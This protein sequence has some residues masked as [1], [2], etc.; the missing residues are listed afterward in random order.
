MARKIDVSLISGNG[1]SN[2]QLLGANTGNVSF[3]S[4]FTGNVI[5]SGN[6]SSGNVYFSNARAIG[7]LVAG[8]NIS[9]TANGLI[10]ANLSAVSVSSVTGNLNVSGNVI[11]NGFVSTSASAGIISS[12][13]NITMTAAG[14]VNINS[15]NVI[16]SGNVIANTFISTG[17]GSGLL[18]S[19]GNVSISATGIVTLTGSSI[20]VNGPLT[21]N[22]YSG[23]FT[24]NVT[25]S[26]SNLYFT[27]ARVYANVVSLLAAKANVSDLSTSNIAEGNNLYYTNA[28]V[29][30]NVIALMPSLQ[31]NNIIIAANG[32]ISANLT[33]VSVNVN[34][35]TGN[36]N[37][38]G[39]VIANG[40]V[41]TSASA[42]IISSTGNITMTAAG[43]VNI[44]ST[45]VIASGNIIA[46]TFISAGAGSGTLSSTGNVSITGVG[47]ITLNS[48]NVI[49]SGNILATKFFG[50][51]SSLTGVGA[52]SFT[53]NTNGIT[54]GSNNL[55]YTNAR[56]YSNVVSALAV[57]ST[58]N[59]A[60]GTN[61]YYTNARVLSN[62]TAYLAANP[63]ISTYGNANV[64]A[65]LTNYTGNIT[66]G[67]VIANTIISPTAIAAT[68]TST[69]NLNIT[70]L[71]AINLTSPNVIASGNIVA[72]NI[73]TGSGSGGS[74]TGA[75]LISAGNI[76]ATT[77][78]N[79]YTANVI[80]SG[81]SIFY[82]NARVLSNITAYLAANPQGGTFANANVSSLLS[83]YTGNLAAGNLILTGGIVDNVGV[84]SISTTSNSNIELTAAGTGRILLDGQAWPH[85][86]GVNGYVLQTNGTGNLFWAAPASSFANANVG[87]FLATYTGNISAGNVIANTILSPTAIA[88]TITS[89]GNLN[90]TAAGAI[91]L[92]TTNVLVSGNVVANTF[93]ATG[94]GSAELTSTSN[95]L[96]S[97]AG[98]LNLTSSNVI[99]NGNLVLRGALSGLTLTTTSIA[100]GSNLYYTNAR[101]YSNVVSALSALSTSNIAEGSNLYYTNARV[102]SNVIAYLA[103]N[104]ASVSFGNANV[105][106]YLTTY[107]GNISAGNVI[108]NSFVS[109]TATS[110][111]LTSTGN[112]N[113]TAAGTINLTTSNVLVS[114]NVVANNFISTGAGSGEVASTSNLLLSAAGNLNLTS[115]NVFVNGN[116]VLRGAL[117]G[118]TLTTSSIA[119][120]SN[121][122]YT[123]A[124]VHSNVI[125][126]LPTY[127]GNIAAGNLVLTGGIIDNVGVLSISTTG[128]SN[129]ELV[130]NGTGR[131]ILDGQAWPHTDGVNGYVLQ[132]N[133]TGNLFWGVSVGSFS[134][135]NVSSFLSTYTGN[136]TA[137]NVIANSFVS[138]TATSA[139]LTSTG[140]L[141]IT[142]AGTVNLTT[143]NVIASGNIIANTF[144]SAGAGSGEIVS[145][146]NLLLSGA[147]NVN[148]T[149]PNVIVNGNLVLRGGIT[150]LTVTTSSVAEG[151]NLYYTNARVYSNV[152]G[153][154]SSY[155]LTAN[156]NTANVNE[157]AASGN[158]Y[159]T[160]ARVVS[161]VI[162][163][164]AANPS[165]S[166]FGNANVGAF[167]TT[168]T[169][170]I[171]A[172]NVIAN[173]VISPFATSGTLNSTGNLNIVSGGTINLTANTVLA[174]GNIVANTFIAT[175]TGSAE[176]S[177][178]SNLLLSATGNLN[179]AG[180]N[181]Y[182]N[183]PITFRGTV[184]GLT[185]AAVTT[186]NVAEAASSGNLYYTNARV[187]SNVI[188]ILGTAG[189]AL[190]ANLTTANVTEL[191]STGGLY[192]TN[193]RVL[194][195]VTAYLAANPQGGTFG[196]ANV[197]A[198]LLTNPTS[199]SYSNANV[200][201]FLTT[202]TG[203]ISAGNVLA[204]TV[205]SPFATS[206]TLNSTGNLNIISGGTINLTA[207]TVLASGN[208]IANT[209]IATG[210][211][212]AE[213]STSSNLLLSATGN[214][215]LAGG[216]I[217]VNS[218]ITFR[219]TVT[220]ISAGGSVTQ[221]NLTT[222]NVTELNNLY[223]TN[224]RVYSNILAALP[225]YTG[226][227]TAGNLIVTGGI[228][229]TTG[230]L[231]V[232]TGLNSN[233]E[234]TATGTGRIV[235][236]GQ[237]WPHTD[238]VNGYSLQTNGT[239]NLFWAA[240][241]GAS[242]A[243]AN[244]GA[245]L[246][247]YTGNLFAGNVTANAFYANG[248]GAAG[249][250]IFS[251]GN[252]N[253]TSGGNIILATGANSSIVALSSGTTA[254]I[255]NG[256]G[257]LTIA[258]SGNIFLSPESG[259]K[260]YAST[261]VRFANYSNVATGIA[262]PLTGDTA[263]NI[264][265][266]TLS[267]YNS[268]GWN[269]VG[270]LNVPQSGTDKT[271]AYTLVASDVGKFISIG[272]S[273]SIVIPDAVFSA[274][275]AI[276]IFNNT[277]TA[278]T[279]TCSIT[280]AYISGT[281]TDK[282]TVTLATRGVASILFIS[283]TVCV[284]TGSV[285]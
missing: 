141:N 203:N 223:Y 67:N 103:A 78:L 195:N 199:G 110:A 68:I 266:N 71:G 222:A 210:S 35:I 58:S 28:R 169:G 281:D 192:Y 7:A 197:A 18:S 118:L 50:D 133:G 189:Y 4:I 40:F 6:T 9:I 240:P 5:E 191:A 30:S 41:S 146:S 100:E 211:G 194:S 70:A 14:A 152:I 261:P 213:L 196:N 187:Y 275:D 207:N 135:A 219:G 139:T 20:V 125:S 285:S 46:N 53:G 173:T 129:I 51:G 10:S 156:L 155:A 96:L 85:T 163:Y 167:L 259:G 79:L 69:G 224:A 252:I 76:S 82:T 265:S 26:A 205:I 217:Y 128:N 179:L 147:G 83:T 270:Y 131:I 182:V 37:V 262:G 117:T 160:N 171:S 1:G 168:Y 66:A 241:A 132:T 239:G 216:N 245:F 198:Y 59:I 3:Q 161:N 80:E 64:G 126:A 123:N 218:P 144:I 228:I 107:T 280:T 127:T 21:A 11:A 134:N 16:A 238:G 150:G 284:I 154:L 172:G 63:S 29:A 273:G 48:G 248:T 250:T 112:L 254:G 138:P 235:L 86:D 174:S 277:G 49:A 24:A 62:V 175:G 72:N 56:V 180:G 61:L 137:G 242:Y 271:S 244:V 246:T 81:N 225:T 57:L 237:A 176:L 93:I 34:N 231:S 279:L 166:N 234:L 124:R 106:A 226:N 269:K 220:G 243:N 258:T 208:I 39:N 136:L 272:T 230:S 32:Q 149:S 193:A 212:S 186:G 55:F 90:I 99:V 111:T 274:G 268:T 113:I 74:F 184:S 209:F 98:N 42:G 278:A 264:L 44:N 251:A 116:L 206:G 232:V 247:T 104:P 109:P 38:T 227:L 92:T 200:A 2:G 256:F 47:N 119:E 60:E 143:A 255:I 45:N 214:L 54:E 84:L 101:V 148:L 52:T 27:N 215:N 177:T 65:Y 36:L 13:G 257:N 15:T 142:A 233:I 221:A 114:G 121:L 88:A 12:T 8:D 140:N 22:S 102:V 204:N 283:G 267:Y 97:A 43:A 77:W 249:G 260:I 185:T 276:S 130:A 91:N 236:D 188:S 115:S 108:A 122:Y 120:G 229:D 33:G 105:G 202:Y 145:T 178:S 95:I 190:T 75:N 158:L 162:A 19:T 157:N 31:G 73:I 263:Y 201:A 159:Y 282:A 94:S 89:T 25:E 17:A 87:A 165:V 164:L 23:I 181:I 183:S 151:S 170:N 253:I 153:I